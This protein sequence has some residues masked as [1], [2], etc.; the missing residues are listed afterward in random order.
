MTRADEIL[1]A[2]RSGATPTPTASPTPATASGDSTSESELESASKPPRKPFSPTA[3]W[4]EKVSKWRT[5]P[6]RNYAKGKCKYGERCSFIHDQA[7]LWVKKRH[8]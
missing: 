7:N 4:S 3:T 2:P 5:A 1:D 8:D 6:C